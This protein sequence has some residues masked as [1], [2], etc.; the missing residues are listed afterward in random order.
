MITDQVTILLLYVGMLLNI[1]WTFSGVLLNDFR[2]E[3]MLQT[4]NT[5][6]SLAKEDALKKLNQ[7]SLLKNLWR[8][9]QK[10]HK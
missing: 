9:V 1:A 2:Y 5:D 4:A 7:L 6:L 3:K 10:V 8:L